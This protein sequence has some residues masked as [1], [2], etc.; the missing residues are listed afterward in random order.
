MSILID[1]VEFKTVNVVS[2]GVTVNYLEN[3][4]PKPDYYSFVSGEKTEKAVTQMGYRI[5]FNNTY[6][7][8]I[9]TD[10][11]APT[12]NAYRTGFGHGAGQFKSK[13]FK[14][15]YARQSHPGSSSSI[16]RFQIEGDYS[17]KEDSDYYFYRKTW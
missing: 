8:I 1:G 10:T 11:L 3:Y 17:F 16:C 9:L 14:C 7:D 4:S 13:L 5:S 15:I 12:T 6:R 2:T